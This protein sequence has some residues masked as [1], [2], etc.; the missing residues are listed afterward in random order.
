MSSYIRIA[1]DSDLESVA[2]IEAAA[3]TAFDAVFGS[4]DWGA[5]PT[6]ASRLQHP[7]F[8]LIAAESEGGSPIG[9]VHVIEHDGEA[10]LEQLAVL[11]THTR[12]GH[13][14]ALVEAAL[15]D[16]RERGASRMTL[17]TFADVP[18]NGPF[19]TALGFDEVPSPDDD[20]HRVL[21]AAEDAAALSSHG[22]RIAMSI[23]LHDGMDMDADAFEA[24]V[25]EELDKL[26]DDMVEGLDNVV[27]VVEDAPENGDDLFGVYEGFAIT[28]RGQYGMGELPDRIVVYRHAH[29]AACADI[30]QL[31]TEVHT[32][33]VHEIAHFYG[34]DDAQLH[35]LGWA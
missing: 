26:P 10:H 33:L 35:E 3:D 21:L 9:F 19:Y 34:I 23:A 17:R 8:I 32:T 20:F 5:P 2:A 1:T 28:E 29:L 25:I 13:G 12:R 6:G 18:W 16:A 15:D 7:G 27:F 31:R 30:D 24:L 4:T 22:R 11:P 14:A